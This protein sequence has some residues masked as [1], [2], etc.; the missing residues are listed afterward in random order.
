MAEE[1][2]RIEATEVFDTFCAMM[3]LRKFSYDSDRE[4]LEIDFSMQGEDLLMPMKFRVLPDRYVALLISP[5]PFRAPEDKR[6]E[7]AV[8]ISEINYRLING[9]FDLDI[10]DGEIL[11]RISNSYLESKLSTELFDALLIT[12]TQTVDRFNDTLLLLAKGSITL[13]QGLQKINE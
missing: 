8:A 9:S 1:T 13:E 6:L 10:R 5:L 4:K 2:E 12:V 7:M 11:F 3:D